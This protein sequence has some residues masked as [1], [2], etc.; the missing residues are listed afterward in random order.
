MT[1][2]G[3][4]P[5]RVG[6]VVRVLKLTGAV[7]SYSDPRQEQHR[8]AGE[9]GEIASITR[10]GLLDVQFAGAAIYSADPI[11]FEHIGDLAQLAYYAEKTPTV[12]ENE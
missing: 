8:L 3:G 11:R 7:V 6:D 2:A 10:Q 5:Y 9:L 12:V 1:K 4:Q